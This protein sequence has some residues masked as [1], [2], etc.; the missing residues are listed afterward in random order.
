MARGGKPTLG[1]PTRYQAIMALAD[2][3]LTIPQIAERIGSNRRA[4]SCLIRYVRNKNGFQG[5]HRTAFTVA[6]KRRG[7]TVNEL[8][9]YILDVVA[10]ENLFDAILDDRQEAAE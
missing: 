3:G 4:V 9:A 1:Y 7:I 5:Y 6:A 2:E 10:R 8:E